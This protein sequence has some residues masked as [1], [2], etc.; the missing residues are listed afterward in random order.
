MFLLTSIHTGSHPRMPGQVF[1]GLPAYCVLTAILH[2]EGL[3]VRCYL[4]GHT[5]DIPGLFQGLQNSQILPLLLNATLLLRLA[6]GPAHHLSPYFP[7][8]HSYIIFF[9]AL[10]YSRVCRQNRF[11]AAFE[12]LSGLCCQYKY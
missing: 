12:G 9:S 11:V 6:E 2:A 5:A 1:A 8:A 3:Q 10:S 7:F 4:P